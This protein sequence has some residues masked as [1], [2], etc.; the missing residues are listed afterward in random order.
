MKVTCFSDTNTLYIEFKPGSIAGDARPGR[1]HAARARCHGTDLRDHATERT[2][3]P[4]FSYE[5]F[6]A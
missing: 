3:I 6:A 2:R 4:T 1:E 5:Q